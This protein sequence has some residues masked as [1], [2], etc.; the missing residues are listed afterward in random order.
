MGRINLRRERWL[1]R[2]NSITTKYDKAII[3]ESRLEEPIG[4]EGK[5]AI[6]VGLF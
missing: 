3:V 1:V 2:L 5:T 4:I 6:P